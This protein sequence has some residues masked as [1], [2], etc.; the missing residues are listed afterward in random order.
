MVNR[1]YNLKE[2][3]YNI[4]TILVALIVW[5]IVSWFAQSSYFPPVSSIL[6]AFKDLAMEGDV[7]GITLGWHIWKSMLR[8]FA[9]F[10]AACA[11]G[12]PLGLLMGLYPKLYSG[13]RGIIEPIRFVP[14]IAWI[15]LSI[16]LLTGFSRYVFIIFIGSFFPVWVLTRCHRM[17]TISASGY[18]Y[19]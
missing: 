4:L 8:I 10:G 19:A 9:G 7:D 1:N 3:G 15:P 14:P 2:I 16:V 13:S 11:L 6:A 18:T 5:S 17:A 12:I